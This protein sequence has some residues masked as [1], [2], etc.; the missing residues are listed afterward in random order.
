ML[1]GLPTGVINF[2]TVWISALVPHFFPNTRIYTAIAL[3]MIPLGATVA[4]LVLPSTTD[5]TN[6]VRW[7]VAASTW[8]AQ[9][10]SAP[11]CASA[12]LL[13]SNVKGNTKKSIVSAGFF[14]AGCAGAIVSPYA[15]GK[16]EREKGNENRDLKYTEGYILNIVCWTCLLAVFSIYLL[17]IKR[18]NR[19]RDQMAA[20]GYLEYATGGQHDENSHTQIGVSEDSDL[21]DLQDKGFRYST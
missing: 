6:C 19:F 15:W 9:L 12:S 20:E 11:L 5:C 13:A 1:V 21:T 7:G 16:K 14:I 4:L 17:L 18:K 3:T 8:L 10:G 2:T